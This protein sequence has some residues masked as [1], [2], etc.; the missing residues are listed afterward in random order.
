MGSTLGVLFANFYIGTVEERV[1]EGTK[2]PK[3]YTRYIDDCFLSFDAPQ[4]LAHLVQKFTENSVLQFTTES[5]TDG[6][7]P[8]LDVLV[9]INDTKI[10]TSVFTKAT[11]NGTVMNARGECSSNYRKS[12][13]AAFAKRAVTHCSTWQDTHNELERI[14]QLLTNNGFPDAIIEH[15]ERTLT[16]PDI[17]QLSSPRLSTKKRTAGFRG[18]IQGPD[19]KEGSL[20]LVRQ[21]LRLLQRAPLLPPR[22]RGHRH[23]SVRHGR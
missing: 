17:L 8:F 6:K 20:I 4:D 12:V 15:E 21:G 14:R 19:I 1:F 9:D 23:T 16:S 13:V 22:D 2:R 7:L 3:V 11:N 5:S 18:E 10:K